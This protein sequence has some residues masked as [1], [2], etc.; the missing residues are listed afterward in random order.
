MDRE[1]YYKFTMFGVLAI[2]FGYTLVRAW[3][4]PVFHDEAV[5]TVYF[6]KLP[7]YRILSRYHPNNHIL[8]TFLI[9][10]FTQIFGVSEFVVRIPA[11]IGHLLYLTGMYKIC[12]LVAKREVMVGGCILLTLNPFMLELFSAAR[13]YGLSLGLFSLAAYFLLKRAHCKGFDEFKSYTFLSITLLAFAAMAHFSFFQIY[14]S[15]LVIVLIFDLVPFGHYRSY[16]LSWKD[17]LAGLW[18]GSI[19]VLA[20][21]LYPVYAIKKKALDQNLYVTGEGFWKDTVTSLVQDALYGKYNDNEKIIFLVKY[22]A[23]I[24]VGVSVVVLLMLIIRKDLDRK[25]EAPGRYLLLVTGW[26]LATVCL[27]FFQFEFFKFKYVTGRL[28]VFFIPLFM[29]TAVVV[30][31]L[32]Q[33][34]QQKLKRTI[35]QASFWF[36]VLLTSAHFYNSMDSKRVYICPYAADTREMLQ[37][38]RVIRQSQGKL[39]APARIATHWLFSPMVNFYIMKDKMT[40]LKPLPYRPVVYGDEDYFYFFSAESPYVKGDADIE[41]D[42]KSSSNLDLKVVNDYE[43]TKTYLAI[44]NN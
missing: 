34:I 29:L 15:F 13:G 32:S 3:F 42:L 23:G 17:W 37:D 27:M 20:F 16:R 7:F 25:D 41:D 18:P 40:W 33:D 26:L 44:K 2:A 11:L 38:V 22:F 6:S 5:T 31:G 30:W 14:I 43:T 19:G 1:K 21:C 24:L 10:G 35:V 4:V 36:L 12:R 8:N 28:A 39:Q 9:K